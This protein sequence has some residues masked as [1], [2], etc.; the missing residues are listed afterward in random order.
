M[1][2][3]NS[4]HVKF[5]TVSSKLITNI[6]EITAQKLNYLAVEQTHTLVTTVHY[7]GDVITSYKFLKPFLNLTELVKM[8]LLF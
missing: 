5:M 1:E 8:P 7:L 4:N 6:E 2:T 3:D